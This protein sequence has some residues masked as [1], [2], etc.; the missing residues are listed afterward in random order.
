MKNWGKEYKIASK[1]CKSNDSW[2]F[3]NLAYSLDA[4]TAMFQASGN[5]KYLDRALYYINNIMQSSV[6]S[7]NLSRSQYK[8]NFLGWANHTAPSLGNDGKEYP[9][10]ESYCWRYVTHLLY[11]IHRSPS[12][13]SKEVYQ[14]QYKICH[15]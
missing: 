14:K 13:L 15:L 6:E 7:S 9:L 5:T 2:Q 8:D 11:V 4:N 12:L 3:Y 10:F 1:Q